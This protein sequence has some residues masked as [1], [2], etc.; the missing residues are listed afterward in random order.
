M[1]VPLFARYIAAVVG[2]L[3]VLVSARSVIGTLIVPR[4][5]SSWLTNQV[6]WVV[7][8][9][10]RA[11]SSRIH[12]HRRRDKVLAGQVAALLLA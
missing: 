4:A 2:V 12:D 9:V 5:V 10:F 3:I 8:R 7:D 6:D 11:A 1:V